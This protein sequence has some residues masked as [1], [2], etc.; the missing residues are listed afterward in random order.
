MHFL[1]L[2]PGAKFE[3]T[4]PSQTPMQPKFPLAKKE[5]ARPFLFLANALMENPQGTNDQGSRHSGNYG[6]ARTSTEERKRAAP[7]CRADSQRSIL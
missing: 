7:P 1:S 5:E 4:T 3:L 2:L 6:M